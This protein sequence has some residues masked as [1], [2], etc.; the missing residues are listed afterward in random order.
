M[1]DAKGINGVAVVTSQRTWLPGRKLFVKHGFEKADTMLP[2]FELFAKRFSQNAPL[3]KF[4]P[5]PEERLEKYA[6]GITIFKSNQCPY[7]SASTR[8]VSEVAKQAN[9]PVRMEQIRSCKEA[10]NSVHPY[11]TFCVILNGKVV[12]YH[13]IGRK[14]LLECLPKTR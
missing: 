5:I 13:P 3:P 2:D 8:V 1:N 12:T 11:G 10:Q 14:E 9:L 4:N 6:T 7:I